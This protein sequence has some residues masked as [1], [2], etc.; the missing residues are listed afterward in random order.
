MTATNLLEDL[1]LQPVPAWWQT[2]WG[3]LALVIFFA[4]ACWLV[5]RLFSRNAAPM[6]SAAKSEE[7][8]SSYSRAFRLLEELR[9]E[10]PKLEGYPFAIRG[11]EIL[12]AFIEVR[13]ER[14][15]TCETSGE[16]L[17]T[18]E[19]GE[20]FNEEQRQ[21]LEEWC[22]L[23]D[24]IKFGRGQMDRQEMERLVRR[25]LRFVH[26]A[27]EEEG[28]VCSRLDPDTVLVSGESGVANATSHFKQGSVL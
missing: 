27:Y 4:A 22:R 19:D 6:P 14:P 11:S 21:I 24:R 23:G 1:T 5:K 20:S 2:P 16:I 26:V 28:I 7:M 17:R 9:N 3:I 15:A 13:F 12:R 8:E 25:A 18:S 10:I